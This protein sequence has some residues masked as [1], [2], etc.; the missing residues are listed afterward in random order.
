MKTDGKKYIHVKNYILKC[1]RDGIYKPGDKIPTEDEIINILGFSRSTVRNAIIQLEQEGYLYKI[2]GSGSF[3][4]QTSSEDRIT[5]YALLYPSSKGIEK[6]LIYGMRLA[7]NDS[8]FK[9]LHLIL[10]KPGKNTQELIGILRSIDTTKQGGIIMIPVLDSSRTVNRLLASTTRKLE[11][12]NFTVVQIDR[13]IPEY[14]GNFI[15]S[16]HYRGA[17]NMVQY[18]IDMGHRNISIIYEH[19]ENSSIKERIRGVKMCLQDN[20]LKLKESNQIKINSI[21]EIANS[22]K[23]LIRNLRQNSTTAVFCF[24]SEITLEIYKLFIANNM[25]IPEDISLCSFDDHCFRRFR[26]GFITAVIQP[27]EDLGYFAVN[28][29]LRELKYKGGEKP[30]RMVMEPKIA[31]RLSVG[32]L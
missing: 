4:R 25:T 11:N 27:L 7:V 31:K 22:G 30:I 5:I 26:D 13:V 9:N 17:Y 32:R 29:I 28:L 15:M 12:N 1:I 6:D 2:H 18:L 20:A 23:E 3:V 14:D 8:S 21:K 19:P 16:D 24:E 10:N